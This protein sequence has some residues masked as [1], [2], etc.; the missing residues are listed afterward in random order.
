MPGPP[1]NPNSRRQRGLSGG[2]VTLL[3][4]R[5]DPAPEL[6]GDH[7]SPATRTAWATWWGSPAA[8]QWTD[9][10]LPSA[11]AMASAYEGAVAG[12]PKAMAEFRQWADR[13]GLSPLARIRNGWRLAGLSAAS[14]AAPPSL[15]SVPLDRDQRPSR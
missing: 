3:G 12:D 4:P 15:R 1:P 7:W 11:V 5:T 6:P 9:A 14:E 13:F 10:D 8:T 2:Y